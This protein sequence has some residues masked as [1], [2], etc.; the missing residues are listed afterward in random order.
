MIEVSHLRAILDYEPT[1]GVLTWRDRSLE[2]FRCQEKERKRV[3]SR[4]KLLKAG[5]VAGHVNQYGY[6][7]LCIE[8]KSIP[9]HRA[10]WAIHYGEWPKGQI[11]HINHNKD[12]NRL[13]NLRDATASENSR[14][15]S[16]PAHNASGAIGVHF[17][18]PS[19]KW[20]A[21]IFH[22]GK[23]IH[24]GAFKEK[25]EAIA[26]RKAANAR[27]DYHENHGEEV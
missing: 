10:A 25:A 11:D 9:A 27:F 13:G 24:L 7:I 2:T 14:N 20:H 22:D 5:K 18:K 12:D 8:H 17:N 21:R 4:W 3:H 26:A 19:G 1:S 23:R 15:R 16:I 6:R